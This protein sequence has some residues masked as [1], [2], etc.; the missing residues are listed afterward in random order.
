[1]VVIHDELPSVTVAGAEATD[2]IPTDSGDRLTEF[3]EVDYDPDTRE[4]M[5]ACWL[6]YRVVQ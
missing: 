3:V 5:Y 1:M 4:T 2:V 6:E